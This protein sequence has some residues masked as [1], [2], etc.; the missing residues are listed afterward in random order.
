MLL[1][2]LAGTLVGVVGAWLN[3]ER[4]EF[5]V[6]EIDI[7]SCRNDANLLRNLHVVTAW[8]HYLLVHH[9]GTRQDKGPT[10]SMRLRLRRP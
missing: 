9:E 8:H 1:G 5:D 4:F 3:L 10:S 7:S 6:D 2:V